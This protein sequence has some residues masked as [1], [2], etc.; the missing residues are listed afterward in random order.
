VSVSSCAARH[1]ELDF[2]LWREHTGQAERRGGETM[3]PIPFTKTR[4]KSDECEPRRRK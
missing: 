1:K 3:G 2:L 4:V